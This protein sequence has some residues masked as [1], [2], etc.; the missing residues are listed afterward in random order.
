MVSTVKY[1]ATLDIQT[2]NS[3]HFIRTFRCRIRYQKVGLRRNYVRYAISICLIVYGNP[4]V[5]HCPSTGLY[6]NR[7]QRNNSTIKTPSFN[8]TFK[9]VAG[10]GGVETMSL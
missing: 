4:W 7:V 10:G 6:V 9:L 1:F 5:H 2:Q 8:L 3:V